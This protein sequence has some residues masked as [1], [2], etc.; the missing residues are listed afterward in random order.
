MNPVKIEAGLVAALGP[1]FP[2]VEIYRGTASS[3]QAPES[4]NLVASC[5]RMTHVGG[6]LYYAECVL[7]MT[8]PALYGAKIF[9]D[10]GAA[11]TAF[12]TALTSPEFSAGWPEGSPTFC[13]LYVQETSNQSQGGEWDVSIMVRLGVSQ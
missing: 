4:L 2:G 12:E 6:P 5:P 1:F 13:G 8:G 10:L 3:V 9:G 7:Q 11:I